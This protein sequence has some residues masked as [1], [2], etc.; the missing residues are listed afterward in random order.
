MGLL[1][2]IGGQYLYLAT[3]L[4]RKALCLIFWFYIDLLDRFS[5]GYRDEKRTTS[6]EA[7]LS[8]RAKGLE[9][10]RTRH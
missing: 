6:T 7:A 4:S 2:N 10:I 1:C 3:T 9:P 5:A 8:V